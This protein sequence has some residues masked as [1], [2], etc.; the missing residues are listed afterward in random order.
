MSANWAWVQ[1]ELTPQF[2]VVS[3]DRAGLGWSEAGTG[4]MDAASSAE[5]LHTAL[6]AAGCRPPYVLAG[7]S[8]GGLVVRAFADR[9]PDDVVGL[10]LV[11][12]SH[13]QQWTHIP[14]SRG[15]PS[16]GPTGSPRRSRTSDYCACS[17]PNGRTSRVFRPVSTP[18]CAPTW[19]DR[20]AGWP[21]P[22]VCSP[23]TGS[24]AIRSMP[25]VTS[26]NCH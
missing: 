14:A 24:R 8:Y 23:G 5:E 17:A 1:Q 26:G 12:A 21:A 6:A 13:P 11:D 10:V 2:R 19:R 16:P 7:H 18:R 20:T 25:P 15:A 22:P 4:R 3:Y 9:H